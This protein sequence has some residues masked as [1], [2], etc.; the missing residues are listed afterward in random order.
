MKTLRFPLLSLA[1][2]APGPLLAGAFVVG[3]ATGGP[4]SNVTI[5]LS[6]A[7]DGQTISSQVMVTVAAPLSIVS[8]TPQQ[9]IAT[10]SSDGNSVTML[11][12]SFAPLPTNSAN[13]CDVVLAIGPAAPPRRPGR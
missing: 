1:L 2:F 4:G 10:C 12:F 11:L 9:G 13:Y 7:G 3:N 6:F 5:P 8:A